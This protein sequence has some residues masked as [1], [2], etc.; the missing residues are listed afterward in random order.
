MIAF[1]NWV[2]LNFCS[3]LIFVNGLWSRSESVLLAIVEDEIH[4]TYYCAKFTMFSP[5]AFV[6]SMCHRHKYSHQMH[7][8]IWAIIEFSPHATVRLLFRSNEKHTFMFGFT[9]LPLE[10]RLWLNYGSRYIVGSIDFGTHCIVYIIA[11]QHTTGCV[12]A[13]GCV[14]QSALCISS[15]DGTHQIAQRQC[16]YCYVIMQMC[17]M[18]LH[19]VWH[20]MGR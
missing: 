1:A 15:E 18:H 2:R 14:L 9:D 7:G 12:S 6:H 8:Y 19:H 4:L 17:A 16:Y 10:R 20:S 13:R 5:P 3:Q 11:I